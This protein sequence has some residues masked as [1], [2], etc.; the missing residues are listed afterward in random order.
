MQHLWVGIGSIGWFQAEVLR[1]MGAAWGIFDAGWVSEFMSEF[2][3]GMTYMWIGLG[4]VRVLPISTL[5]FLGPRSP[6]VQKMIL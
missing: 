3:F 1:W 4:L 2:F 5:K 6:V